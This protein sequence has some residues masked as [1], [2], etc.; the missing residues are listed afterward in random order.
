MRRSKNKNYRE[1]EVTNRDLQLSVGFHFKG[2]VAAPIERTGDAIP[3]RDEFDRV[4]RSHSV[5]LK[6][7]GNVS[8]DVAN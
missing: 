8:V 1:L 5:T 4:S 7:G 2:G 3:I 6:R